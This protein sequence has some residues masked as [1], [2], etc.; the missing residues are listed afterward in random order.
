ML[1]TIEVILHAG[2]VLLLPL[3]TVA[4]V[5]RELPPESTWLGRYYRAEKHLPLVSNLFVLSLCLLSI[6]RLVVHF[7]LLSRSVTDP[8]ETVVG[9]LFAVL[10]L[11]FGALLIRA[12]RTL[13]RRTDRGS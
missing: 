5:R 8:A 6:V 12:W 11:V 9:W 4:L 1:S 10:W 13:R 2:V 3:A 7:G